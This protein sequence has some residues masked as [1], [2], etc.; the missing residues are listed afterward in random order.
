LNQAK[1]ATKEAFNSESSGLIHDKDFFVAVMKV[2]SKN[3]GITSIETGEDF[4]EALKEVNPALGK[5]YDSQE[6]KELHKIAK[7]FSAK[8]Q[9][10]SK[11]KNYFTARERDKGEFNDTGRR[12]FRVCTEENIQAFEDMKIEEVEQKRGVEE[13]DLPSTSPHSASPHSISR[14]SSSASLTTN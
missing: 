4:K 5:K 1:E 2:A 9:S 6:A 12:L 10:L 3:R 11:E 14:A 13:A 8:F 7:Y